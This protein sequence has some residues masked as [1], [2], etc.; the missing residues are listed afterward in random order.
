MPA[1]RSASWST[2]LAA[3]SCVKVSLL[4]EPGESF[5]SEF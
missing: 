3:K 4:I 1:R 2:H 5:T